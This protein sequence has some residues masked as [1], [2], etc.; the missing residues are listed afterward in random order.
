MS[1]AQLTWAVR[2]VIAQLL[3]TLPKT[4]TWTTDDWIDHFNSRP[5]GELITQALANEPDA[6][7]IVGEAVRIVQSGAPPMHRLA[8]QDIMTTPVHTIQPN[9]SIRSVLCLFE[10]KNFHH[11]VVA[12]RDRLVGVVSDRDVL[13]TLITAWQSTSDGQPDRHSALDNPVHQ[14]MSRDLITI[15]PA[16]ELSSAAEK[17]LSEHISC[18]PVVDE[19]VRALGIVTIRD[20]AA[21]RMAVLQVGDLLS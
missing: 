3:A 21:W 16:D 20:I 9:D 12:E 6:A 18:L 4:R 11:T 14:I 15:G 19:H 17:M 7:A 5:S 8:V 1:R 13:R 10:Q 2:N